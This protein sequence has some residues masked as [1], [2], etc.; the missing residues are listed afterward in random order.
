MSEDNIAKTIVLVLNILKRG[1]LP[2][3]IL[4]GVMAFLILSTTYAPWL[5]ILALAVA[6]MFLLGIMRDM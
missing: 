1:L 2:F 6:F 5:F 4:A 3:S